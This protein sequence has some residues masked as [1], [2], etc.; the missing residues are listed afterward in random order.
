MPEHLDRQAEAGANTLI[1]G[2]HELDEGLLVHKSRVLLEQ[3]FREAQPDPRFYTSV[4]VQVQGRL[5]A[6]GVTHLDERPDV[7][8]LDAEI[9]GAM[10]ELGDE[11]VAASPA[12]AG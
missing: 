1:V 10:V 8:H 5:G 11:Q 2:R 4:G 12:L 6:R 9:H 3:P 7:P